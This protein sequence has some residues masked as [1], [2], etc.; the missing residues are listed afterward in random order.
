[1]SN[2][3]CDSF[4]N[5]LKV[6]WAW[7][8]DLDQPCY[9]KRASEKA[10]DSLEPIIHND[11][12]SSWYSVIDDFKTDLAAMRV[13]VFLV[14][15]V[16]RRQRQKCNLLGLNPPEVAEEAAVRGDA[17][18]FKHYFQLISEADQK[19]K[20]MMI[21]TLRLD[22]CL[23]FALTKRLLEVASRLAD[24]LPL[25][26]L[27]VRH[28]HLAVNVNAL[29]AVEVLVN[30]MPHSSIIQKSYAG[31]ETVL[32]LAIH[33]GCSRMVDLLVTKVPELGCIK[34][35]SRTPLMIA[36]D[37][38]VPII[39][40]I[41]VRK[42]PKQAL[43]SGNDKE[44]TPLHYAVQKSQLKTVR[45]LVSNLSEECLIKAG[46][47]NNTALHDAARIGNFKVCEALVSKWPQYALTKVNNLQYTPLHL[48]SLKGHFKIVE[49]LVDEMSH[50][51]LLRENEGPETPLQLATRGGFVKIQNLLKCAMFK[52]V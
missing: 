8:T 1:M 9:W 15:Y 11:I 41:L 23:T 44:D 12:K 40:E 4:L 48:A 22:I 19:Q 49:M 14:A 34:Y 6:C 10:Y 24:F 20:S 21:S 26:S 42:M 51:A 33:N 7:R 28:L 25:E 30:K 39:V 38:A 18:F 46:N 13:I 17:T 2:L 52:K 5:C 3:D 16:Q 45:L 37:N 29:K 32:H 50:Y 35:G 43:I 31:N 36:I 27:A 47:Q